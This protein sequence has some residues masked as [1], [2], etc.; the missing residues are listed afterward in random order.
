[1][2]RLVT[3]ALA[4]ALVAGAASA[5]TIS[6]SDVSSDATPA[7]Q[8]DASFDFSVAGSTL[9]LTVT[10]TGSD[11]NINQVYWNGSGLVS[12]LSLTSATHSAAGDVTSVWAPV[13]VGSSA[14]GFGSFTFALTDGVGETNVNILEPGESIVFVLSITGS[15]GY[16]DV[17]FIVANG[18]GYV[19]AAKFVNGPDDPEDPGN[20]DSAFGA[21]VPEPAAGALLLLGLAG[22]AARRARGA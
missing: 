10:N 21:A 15:G 6:L 11:F 17:D 2:P 19:A 20:E 16:A 14:D 18:S 4:S 5:T 7:S 12:A 13:E 3:L 9:T 1:V 22:L 8:L